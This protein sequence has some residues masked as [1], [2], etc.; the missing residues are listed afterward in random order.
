ML[1][2]ANFRNFSENFNLDILHVI[3]DGEWDA[4]LAKIKE[5]K[6]FLDSPESTQLDK[7]ENTDAL[8]LLGHGAWAV[9][10]K[11]RK[12][13]NG[14]ALKL[15][16]FAIQE[17][18][19]FT[20]KDYAL[21]GYLHYVKSTVLRG[22]NQF[23]EAVGEAIDAYNA[24]A[25][26]NEA[27]ELFQHALNQEGL[28][29]MRLGALEDAEES[30]FAE[31]DKLQPV[32]LPEKK[33]LGLFDAYQLIT[34]AEGPADIRTH[35]NRAQLLLKQGKPEQALEHAQ[36]AVAYFDP[37]KRPVDRAYD[38]TVR[39]ECYTKLGKHEEAFRDL[40]SAFLT[41]QKCYPKQPHVNAFRTLILLAQ[42]AAD[43]KRPNMKYLKAAHDMQ[44]A[45]KLD[46]G[47][48]FVK[49]L[50]AVSEKGTMAKEHSTL[51]GDL[52]RHQRM[53][54]FKP[55]QTAR[56]QA[57]ALLYPWC[58]AAKSLTSL[59]RSLYALGTG[60]GTEATAE[61]KAFALN[62]LSSV[63]SALTLVTKTIATLLN[64][65]YSEN[66]VKLD[67]TNTETKIG[68]FEERLAEEE[69]YRGTMALGA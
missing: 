68:I 27:T 67:K 62:A 47:H 8:Y 24:F 41:Y 65:G 17:A 19:S 33:A 42:A 23:D 31:M 38:L 54:L 25:D 69:A 52:L 46:D 34:L 51:A 16:D 48:D 66:T 7:A 55:Y 45:L 30:L 20:K 37:F 21:C 29:N 59:A 32:A 11:L 64:L 43:T 13:D 2:K 57:S 14:L 36:K 53:T 49:A 4:H 39:A 9:G 58:F 56:Y 22:Q 3:K 18:E 50:K 44:A 6:T 35:K 61:L 12:N 28:A 26:A 15:I 40:Q 60:S 5:L 10:A 63:L 1:N